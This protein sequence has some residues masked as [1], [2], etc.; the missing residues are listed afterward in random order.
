M[1]EAEDLRLLLLSLKSVVDGTAE[2]ESCCGNGSLKALCTGATIGRVVDAAE[3]TDT[4]GGMSSSTTAFPA[5][6][7]F[8]IC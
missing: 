1:D 5:N 6:T 3:G 4:S 2:G 7:F 8:F